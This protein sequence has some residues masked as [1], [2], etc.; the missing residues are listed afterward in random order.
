[1]SFAV[2]QSKPPFSE[3]DLN[4]GERIYRFGDVWVVTDQGEPT[5]EKVDAVLAPPP[6]PSDAER[7]VGRILSDPIALD[8]LKAELYKS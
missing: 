6:A 2:W 8:M 3:S 5:H 4:N 1:M 7:L